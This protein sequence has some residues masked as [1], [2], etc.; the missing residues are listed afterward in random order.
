MECFNEIIQVKVILW[1]PLVMHVVV[2]FPLDKVLGASIPDA[3]VQ[4]PF[5]FVVLLAIYQ[6]RVGLRKLLST[7][8]WIHWHWEELHDWE[9]W[10]ESSERGW[11]FNS[12]QPQSDHFQDLEGPEAKGHKLLVWLIDSDVRG[13]NENHVPQLE[14]GGWVLKHDMSTSADNSYS[15]P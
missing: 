6:N 2:A 15:C 1:N 12:V 5:N 3:G 14:L 4:D 8:E 7:R 10:M 9:D 11:E 13:I